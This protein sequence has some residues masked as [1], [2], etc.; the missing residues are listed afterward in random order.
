MVTRSSKV[1]H[2]QTVRKNPRKDTSDLCSRHQQLP[3]IVGT[4]HNNE[5]CT[6]ERYTRICSVVLHQGSLGNIPPQ[7]QGIRVV[8]KSN[9]ALRS[10]LVRSKYPAGPNKQ[11]RVLYK[12]SCVCGK[13]YIG[14]TEHH[15]C[16][17]ERKN[18]T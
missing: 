8:F 13:V 7:Q 10:L 18:T 3:I 5:P 2:R 17:R 12:I 14:D 16:E 9:T 6:K 11:D 4:D 1:H 15:P